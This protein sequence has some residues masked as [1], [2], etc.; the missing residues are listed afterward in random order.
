M[1]LRDEENR[2]DCIRRAHEEPTSSAS[3]TAPSWRRKN[4]KRGRPG[5]PSYPMGSSKAIYGIGIFLLFSAFICLSLLIASGVEYVTSGNNGLLS[6]LPLSAEGS[7]SMAL[8][9]LRLDLPIHGRG[10]I[11][12]PSVIDRTDEDFFA[13]DF[14][15]LEISRRPGRKSI[16]IAYGPNA[17]I[18]ETFQPPDDESLLEENA[19]D[20]YYF[21]FDDD[22]IRNPY[23]GHKNRDKAKTNHCRRVAWHRDFFPNCN[24]FHATDLRFLAEQEGV[25]YIG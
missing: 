18:L 23:H 24:E 7:H 8:T 4:K 3:S 19:Y 9:D 17:K 12:F 14:G 1:S 16:H 21:A 10:R 22:E 13:P 5:F 25:S 2:E 20:W 11:R 15:G 6:V